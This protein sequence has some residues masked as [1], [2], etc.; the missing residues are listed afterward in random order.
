MQ[1]DQYIYRFIS[2]YDLYQLC[3]KKKLRLSLLAVQEDMNEGMGAVL[4]L[5]SPQWGSFFSNSDQIAGQHLQKL[6]NTY[7]T[8]WSTEPDSVAMWALYSPNKDGIRIR[9]TVGRLKATLADYQEATSLW[10]HTNHIGGTELLTWHWELALVRYI[11]LNIFIEEMNKAYTEFRTSCTE[12]A[13]GNP[14][15]WTAED[16]YL[17][18]APIF[19]ERFRKA[20]TMDYFLKNS[21]FSHENEIRGVVRAGIRNELDFE[22]WKRLDDPFRQLFKSAEPGV[23]PSFV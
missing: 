6:H 21:S 20:F 14:E 8:C 19:A 11:N 5:A 2:F 1:D 15:W 9:S 18:E 7:I 22:G 16:G 23:L 13:K 4:Q 17:T 12:S 10:K 3:K